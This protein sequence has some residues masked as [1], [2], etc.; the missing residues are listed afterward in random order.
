MTL[1]AMLFERLA[2][3]GRVLLCTLLVVGVLSSQSA[4][5]CVHELQGQDGAAYSH[6][7]T[8]RVDNGRDGGGLLDIYHV[9]HNCA[10]HTHSSA[11]ASPDGGPAATPLLTLTATR[12][13]LIDARRRDDPGASPDQ[14]PKPFI[15]IRTV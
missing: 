11:T 9:L 14:P 7:D 8:A 10:C 6:D 13:A 15:D 3:G 12:F 5:F 2:A 1:M 4:G